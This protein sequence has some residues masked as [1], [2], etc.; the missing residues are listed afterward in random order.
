VSG[1]VIGYARVSTRGQSLDSQVDALVA[2]GAMRVFQ[3]Y[4]SGATQACRKSKM[5]LRSALLVWE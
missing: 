3:E 4:A 1:N 2:A 5:Q